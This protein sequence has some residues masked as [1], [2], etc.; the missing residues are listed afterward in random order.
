M[1]E[2]PSTPTPLLAHPF[3][4]SELC[5]LESYRFDAR[6][7]TLWI[8]QKVDGSYVCGQF[9]FE[10]FAT[11]AVEADPFDFV[12][13]FVPGTILQDGLISIATESMHLEQIRRAA[14]WIEREDQGT[15]L[16]FQFHAREFT[17]HVVAS[18][19]PEVVWLDTPPADAIFGSRL[20]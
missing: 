1:N 8:A 17:V 3:V 10:S 6:G 13:E 19:V 15:D 4:A 11:F 14:D 9:S 2:E 12:G 20:I 16:H 5:Y 18:R 7:L